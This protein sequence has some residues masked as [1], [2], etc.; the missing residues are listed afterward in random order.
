MRSTPSVSS[1]KKQGDGCTHAQNSSTLA[2]TACTKSA[3]VCLRAQN[4][5]KHDMD[6]FFGYQPYQLLGP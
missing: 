6:L 4:V 2:K 5:I 1:V 3:Y